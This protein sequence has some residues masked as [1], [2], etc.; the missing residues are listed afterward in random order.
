MHD[1]NF[2][3]NDRSIEREIHSSLKDNPFVAV[4]GTR[5]C[6]KTN[7]DINPDHTFFVVPVD[8]VGSVSESMDVVTMLD[9]SDGINEIYKH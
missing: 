9:L 5:Q 3:Y 7:N 6:V 4:M 2:M 8:K 1:Y